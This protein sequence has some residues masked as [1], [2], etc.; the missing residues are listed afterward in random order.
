MERSRGSGWT[1]YLPFVPFHTAPRERNMGWKDPRNVIG[2]YLRQASALLC[3]VCPCCGGGSDLPS[4]DASRGHAA[5]SVTLAWDPPRENEDGSL[6]V[7]DLAGFR[8]YL[9]L[10]SG[11]YDRVLDVGNVL[12][13][14]IDLEAF[15]TYFVAVTAYDAQGQESVFSNE[16]RFQLEPSRP[17]RAR[18]H[19]ASLREA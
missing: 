10:E 3:L 18:S 19:R 1:P 12:V 14:R 2:R 4:M 11:T 16:V 15:G 13:M 8:V 5:T 17:T 6:P 7:H 9:G